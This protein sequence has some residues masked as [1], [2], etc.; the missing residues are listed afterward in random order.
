M[1]AAEHTYSYLAPSSVATEDGRSELTLATSGGRDAHRYF[2]TG[3]LG[4]SGLTVRSADARAA[5]A[6]IG[7]EVS[8]SSKL[9]RVSQALL[10]LG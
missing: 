3:F 4:R 1:A 2:F 10:D 5:L 9:G 6:R 8:R 7:G